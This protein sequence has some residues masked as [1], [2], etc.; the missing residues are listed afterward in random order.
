MFAGGHGIC[1]LPVAPASWLADIAAHSVLMD[2]PTPAVSNYKCHH[3]TG[4]L[5]AL[6]PTRQHRRPP[7]K[8][9]PRG[10]CRQCP[11]TKWETE[12]S[13]AAP[14]HRARACPGRARRVA[15][16]CHTAGLAT[17]GNEVG[18]PPKCLFSPSTPVGASDS[19]GGCEA[20]TRPPGR[21][22]VG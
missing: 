16:S 7:R 11:R 13:L 1:S 22:R 14:E 6:S 4:T 2:P 5:G 21:L 12:A 19:R 15:V 9:V 8:P 20:V 3:H 17:P 18:L 10:K